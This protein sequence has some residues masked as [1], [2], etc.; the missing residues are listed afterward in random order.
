MEIPGFAES[1][2][3][4]ALEEEEHDEEEGHEEEEE[5][6]GLI[7]N[8]DSS[9]EGGAAAISIGDA[10]T[11]VGFSVSRYQTDYGVPGAHHHEEEE[12]GAPGAEEEEEIIRID[13]DQTRYD[14]RGGVSLDGF[15]DSVN[16][17]LSRNDY[18]HVELE[19]SEIGTMF[20]TQATD[21]RF[22]LK[23]EAR[24]S[25]EGMIGVQYKAIDFVALGDEAFVPPSDTTQ[26]SV[27]AFEEYSASDRLTL[28]FSGRAEQQEIAS[29]GRE[30]YDEWAYGASLGAIFDISDTL[31][32]S[33]NLGLSERHPTS[34]EL[35]ADGPHLAVQR[36]ERG[37]ETLGNGLF[38][39]ETSASVDLTLRGDFD[40]MQFTVTGFTNSVDDY[41]LLRPTS[42]ED[43]G[44]QV[45]EFDQADVEFYGLEAELVFDLMDNDY[46]HLHTRLVTD[47]VF[48]E[49]SD[50]GGYLPQLTPL[51]YGASLHFVADRFEASVDAMYHD[52]QGKVAENELFTDD[53]TLISAE[54][55]TRVLDDTMLLFLRG[56]N[57]SDEDA[58]RHNSPL[59][60]VA[61]LPG[62]SVIAGLRWDF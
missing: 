59:K 10:D 62:R 9:T 46:G 6:F 45:F 29:S 55:N 11:W 2:R 16:F 21:A 23:H 17:M 33:A 12:G 15:F 57:L 13:L 56:T 39:K 48:G 3:L 61:P 43:D 32:F 20:D 31:A 25:F 34:T 38:E 1:A 27:F 52:S 14:M 22:E 42:E 28:Q 19:G 37:S 18:M 36:F 5:V 51:R 54:I 50:T 40:T 35:Y 8:S 41:I 30:K 53:Y 58:R 49:E 44:L 4:R 7:E 60:D 26:V 47:Y 24:S